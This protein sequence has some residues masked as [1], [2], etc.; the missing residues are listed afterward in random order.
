MM[1]KMSMNPMNL[2]KGIRNPKEFVMQNISKMTPN[3]MIGQLVEMA[4]RGQTK[5]IEQFARNV[6]KEKGGD[7]DKDFSEFS[8]FINQ[9]KR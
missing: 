3:P 5:E 1:P 8:G 7:Y 4:E 2:L 6:Y 9:L